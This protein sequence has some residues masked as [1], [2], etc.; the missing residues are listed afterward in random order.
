M[1]IE[2]IPFSLM[3]MGLIL[4]INE[5]KIIGFLTTAFIYMSASFYLF[6]ADKF[7]TID[8]LIAVFSGIL[9]AIILIGILFELLQWPNGAEM[10]ASSKLTL[11]FSVLFAV[12][13]VLARNLEAERRPF[14]FTMSLKLLSRFLILAIYFYASGLHHS[15]VV[16]I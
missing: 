2:G 8:V 11:N 16:P 15:L 1:L 13:V 7:K 14:E 12:L 9:M 4:N 10:L 3:A 5:L 6:K